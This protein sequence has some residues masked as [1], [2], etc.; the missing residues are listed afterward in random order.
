[1]QLSGRT[2]LVT[3][4]ASGLGSAVV[5][6]VVGAGGRSVVIDLNADAGHAIEAAHAGAVQFVHG[7]VTVEA[8]MQR[9]VDV[10]VTTFNGI[11]GLVNAAGIPAA[12]RV[13]PKEAIQPLSHF[14]RVVR[15]NLI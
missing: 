15:V 13:L 12:E 5:E 14:E 10:G 7:D 6:M 8:D 11:H 4:G 3:G 9:A 2:V 1:M